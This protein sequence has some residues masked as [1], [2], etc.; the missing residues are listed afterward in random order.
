MAG[1]VCDPD[2]GQCV[3]VSTHHAQD[4]SA[5]KPGGCLQQSFMNMISKLKIAM[6][7]PFTAFTYLKKLAKMCVSVSVCT[8]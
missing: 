5:C 4:C 8:F 2:S 3:C 1:T 7:L 6:L